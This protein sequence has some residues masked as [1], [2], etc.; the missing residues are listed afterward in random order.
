MSCRIGNSFTSSQEN[1]PYVGK[2]TA[3]I[4]RMKNQKKREKK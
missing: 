4:I 2:W 1:I 3:K